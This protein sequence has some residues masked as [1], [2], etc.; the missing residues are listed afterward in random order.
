MD[1]LLAGAP[2]KFYLLI[3]LLSLVARDDYIGIKNR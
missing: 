3:G 1:V 2:Q